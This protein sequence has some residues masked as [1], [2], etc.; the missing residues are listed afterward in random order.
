[1]VVW[2]AAV[3]VIQLLGIGGFNKV[4]TMKT[5]IFF[6]GAFYL[7]SLLNIIDWYVFWYQNENLALKSFKLLKIKYLDRFPSL[8][9][10]L[11][12]YNPQ[13]FAII[14]IFLLSFSVYVFFN[15]KRTIYK[16]LGITSCIFILQFIFSIM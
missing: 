6:A 14:L 10:P 2:Q 16:L 11:F 15:E 8:I 7:I 5:K 12:E 9:R 13:P 4:N 1:M 3:E